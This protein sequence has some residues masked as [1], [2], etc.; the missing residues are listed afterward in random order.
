LK[1]KSVRVACPLPLPAKANEMKRLYARITGGT[2]EVED[3]SPSL[4]GLLVLAAFLCGV[5]V[6]MLVYWL[7]F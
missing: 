4:S 3:S 2:E 6:A 5:L 1:I 7:F